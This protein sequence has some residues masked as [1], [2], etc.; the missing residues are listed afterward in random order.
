MRRNFLKLGDKSTMGGV[1]I[2]GEPST[3]HHG[4]PLTYIGARI[5]CSA[6]GSTG[7]IVPKGPRWPDRFMGKLC[8][9]EGDLCVCKCHPNP[10]I[11]SSQSTMYQSFDFEN[12]AQMGFAPNGSALKKDPVGDFDEQVRVIDENGQPLT[13]VP[14]HIKT[15]GGATHKGLTDSQGFCPRVYTTNAAR[16][17]IAVGIKALERWSK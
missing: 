17:D 1:V 2:E 12:L 7:H 11:L 9:L 14:F 10:V 6:C 4:T 16:L 15:V 3:T 13:G 5:A 8:A